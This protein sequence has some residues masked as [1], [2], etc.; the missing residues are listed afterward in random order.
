MTL[1]SQG[2]A[3]LRFWGAALLPLLAFATAATNSSAHVPLFV[4][5]VLVLVSL[6]S[7]TNGSGAAWATVDSQEI[8]AH[9]TFRSSE[10]IPLARIAAVAVRQRLAWTRRSILPETLTYISVF[11]KD[12]PC[13]I[14]IRAPSAEADAFLFTLAQNAKR[15]GL[16]Q[17]A[18]FTLPRRHYVH[19]LL[20]L[21]PA[22]AIC[23]VL[24][25]RISW[26]SF[27]LGVAV[28]VVASAIG[29]RRFVNLAQGIASGK[30]PPLV[31]RWAELVRIA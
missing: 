5:L 10:S 20:P 25:F 7:Q 6:L 8:A 4:F 24:P 9:F 19:D 17:I 15:L 22:L 31:E 21:L 29:W 14:D 16:S 1:M 3:E 11:R 26:P 28:F 23:F 18:P 30:V 12:V 27:G 2:G 13:V